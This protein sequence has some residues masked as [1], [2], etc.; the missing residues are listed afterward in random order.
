MGDVGT[1]SLYY[2]PQYF[3]RINR[4][5]GIKEKGYNYPETDGGR[6]AEDG[7]RMTEDG[8]RK[9]DDRGRMTEDGGRKSEVGTRG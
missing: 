2:R 5:N 7:R 8:G 1:L 3:D 9:A 4:I 6:K